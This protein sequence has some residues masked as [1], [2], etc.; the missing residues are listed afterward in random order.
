MEKEN[1]ANQQSHAL[2]GKF[3]SLKKNPTAPVRIL[4]ATATRLVPG[5]GHFNEIE[6]IRN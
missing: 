2:A 5:D 6:F 1:T 3:V 4:V